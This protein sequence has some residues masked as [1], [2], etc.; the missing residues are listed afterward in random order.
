M[1]KFSLKSLVFVLASSL[2]CG[3]TT[4]VLSAE[5][6]TLQ[7]GAFQQVIPV[8]DIVQFAE[9]GKLSSQLK[10]YQFLLN[11]S[12][13]QSLNQTWNID[14]TLM[15]N[16]LD[17]FSQ[18]DVG[19]NLLSR[20]QSAF[21][22]LSLEALKATIYLISRQSNELTVVNFL[23]A[24]PEEN[25]NI[26]VTRIAD[27]V[28]ELN[29]ENLHSQFVLSGLK[30]VLKV[31]DNKTILPN[32]D[33]TRQGQQAVNLKTVTLFDRT[34]NRTLITD[35]YYA[36]EPQSPLILMSHGFASDRKFLSYLA[37]HLTS[38]G[39]T[40]VAVEHPNS[41]QDSI[42]QITQNQNLSQ[43][44]P[45]SEFVDRPHDL[46]FTL[47]QL[48]I[49][50]QNDPQLQNKLNTQ[51]VTLIGHSL[52]GYTVLAVAGAKID[53][54]ALK[55]F[56]NR[57]T[58]IQRSPADWLQC[59]ATNLPD[60]TNLQLQDSRITQVIALNPL[61]GQIF[62]KEGLK[63]IRIPTLILASGEDKI[64]PL[65]ENQLRPFSQL[66]TPNKYLVTFIEGTH[67]SI[68]EP[69]NNKVLGSEKVGEAVEPLHHLF[70]GLS[71]AFIQQ[72][73][74][75]GKQYQP[76][77]SPAY[78]QKQSTSNFSFYLN[79]HLPQQLQQWL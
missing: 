74:P 6:I 69:R 11:D 53:L 26:D 65:V 27:M 23:K 51:Q 3:I 54:N 66:T 62:G 49:L 58:I 4:P 75:Q 5:K 47:D 64:T 17:D 25:L 20:L 1:I 33:P 37:R 15:S 73:T 22:E 43:I 79:Q 39:F 41:N 28:V 67:L 77:L 76:F 78:V 70:K 59:I 48:A 46:S 52:G 61:I 36:N 42:S 14:P 57:Q 35:I 30:N 45:A 7:I 12:V 71:L 16:V 19:E 24:Y 60:S 55:T 56:C 9:T 31:E 32:F 72:A 18:T 63:G 10:F 29:T 38:Y 8:K 40:V 44:L 13:R 2:T 34:R 68:T 21:P 50:N